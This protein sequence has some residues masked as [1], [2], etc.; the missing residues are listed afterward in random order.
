MAFRT[1]MVQLDL[2]GP[3]EP[4]LRFGQ[5]LARRFE[6]SLIAFAAAE[7][8]MVAPVGDNAIGAAEAMR[9]QVED[10]EKRLREIERSCGASSAASGRQAGS[11]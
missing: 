11:A 4:R 3:A 6:A 5:E 8:D 1:I 7:A 10:I 9:L 2:D